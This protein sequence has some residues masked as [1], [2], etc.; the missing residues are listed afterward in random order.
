VVRWVIVILRRLRLPQVLRRQV[1][2]RWLNVLELFKQRQK[3]VGKRLKELAFL[4]QI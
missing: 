2:P 4:L 3:H 1:K